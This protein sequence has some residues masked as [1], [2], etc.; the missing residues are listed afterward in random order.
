MSILRFGI[1]DL[2]F[3]FGYLIVSIGFKI[4]VNCWFLR[5]LENEK[6]N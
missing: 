2:S 6:G 5:N 3:D 4:L 1:Y